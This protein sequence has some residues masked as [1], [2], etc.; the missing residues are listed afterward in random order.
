MVCGDFKNFQ[1]SPVCGP[2][3]VRR[4]RKLFKVPLCVGSVVCGDF[5]NFSKFPC[6]WALCCVETLKIFKVPLCVGSVVCGDFENFQSSP[7]CGDF[8]IF[9]KN[10][11]YW[12]F[13]VCGPCTGDFENFCKKSLCWGISLRLS[14]RLKCKFA[15]R[16]QKKKTLSFIYFHASDQ[17]W[18]FKEKFDFKSP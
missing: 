13:P 3:A 14:L 10:S 6:V 7:V 11:L 1:N 12:G 15:S 5:E 9:L 17:T 18:I 4:L 8:E 2:C 16:P